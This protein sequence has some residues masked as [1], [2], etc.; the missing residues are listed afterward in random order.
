V[1]IP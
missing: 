1:S